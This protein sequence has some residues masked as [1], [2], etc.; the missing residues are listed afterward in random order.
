MEKLS[1]I[2]PVYNAENTLEG[3]VD[4]IL[5]LSVVD[6]ELILVNDASKDRS[7]QICE[8]YAKRYN[9]VSVIHK[10][11]NEG[12]AAARNTGIRKAVGEYLLFCDADD[13]YNTKE[14]QSFL[15]RIPSDSQTLFGFDFRDVWPNGRDESVR[16]TGGK[17]DLRSIN[18]KIGY[19]STNKAHKLIGY[20]VWNKLYKKRILER[21]GIRFLERIELGH[22]D[23]WA[24]DLGFNLQ[25]S[26]C[27]DDVDVCKN[28]VYHITKHGTREQQSEKS[29]FD[30]IDH[31]LDIFVHLQNMPAYMQSET[32]QKEFW[33]IAIWH[34]KRY[35][36]LE[37]GAKGIQGLRVAC[38]QSSNWLELE[39]WI[40]AAIKEWKRYKHRWNEQDAQDYY[41]MLKYLITGNYVL[42][43]VQ[44][45]LLW[46]V[47]P[48]LRKK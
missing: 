22:R 32:C 37:T 29:L 5:D 12:Q 13:K 2:V 23:D 45:Y 47:Y 25:Y 33:K 19:L 30:R 36:Y 21:Y 28:P 24:E 1:I 41:N 11:V 42:Y 26:M 43:K 38:M 48:K 15:T 7:G 46:K 44:S 4:S 17:I 18:D 31:M 39:K 9:M 10:A 40:Q 34:M 20:S 6:F 27:I 16:Y 3:C 8:E 35:F 14:L